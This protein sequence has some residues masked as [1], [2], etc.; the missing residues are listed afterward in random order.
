M[1]L[2]ICAAECLRRRRHWPASSAV[3]LRQMVGGRVGWWMDGEGAMLYDGSLLPRRKQHV[4]C[5]E[6]GSRRAQ[7]SDFDDERTSGSVVHSAAE[8]LTRA[9]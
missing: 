1:S 2:G 4:G 7:A 8:I 5:G 9:V 6:V 3:T